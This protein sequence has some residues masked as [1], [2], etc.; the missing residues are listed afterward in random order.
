[1][2]GAGRADDVAMSDLPDWLVTVLHAK[3]WILIA[4]VVVVLV[5]TAIDRLARKDES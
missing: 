2:P 4:I 1:V 5:C 3:N